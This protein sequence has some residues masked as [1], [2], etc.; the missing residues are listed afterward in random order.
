MDHTMG[1]PLFTMAHSPK[2]FHFSSYSV[3][4]LLFFILLSMPSEGISELTASWIPPFLISH[5]PTELIIYIMVIFKIYLLVCLL[6]KYSC[7]HFPTTTL[8]HLPPSLLP[9]LALSMC[10]L[11]KPLDD[12]SPSFP[13]YPPSPLLL[14]SVCAFLPRLWFYFACLFVLLF[15]FHS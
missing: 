14:L 2:S 6:F 11:Y 15:R 8:P 13:C 12:P 3:F 4:G 5:P 1:H 7:L 9:S 10:P